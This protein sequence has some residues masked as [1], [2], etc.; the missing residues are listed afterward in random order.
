M[1][2]LITESQFK[3][4]VLENNS[5]QFSE[6]MKIMYSFAKNIVQRVKKKYSLNTKLLLTWGA[7][8]G[9]LVMP[10]DGFIKTG[11][12][13]LDDNQT[14]LILIGCAA[15]MFYDNKKYFERIFEE[16]KNQNLEEPFKQTL[17][18]GLELKKTFVNFISSLRI[19][20]GSVSEI[21]SY[22]FLVPII[23]EIIDFLKTGDF[24]KNLDLVVS[25]IIGSG[26]VLVVAEILRE[27]LRQIKN[28]LTIQ[29]RGN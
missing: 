21:T 15:A 19:S 20:L 7:A 22:G 14:A 17:S 27:L 2:F 12:F 24:E 9:G 13:T 26:L 6:Y 8:L 3:T 23:M 5:E 10:L 16:I 25:R 4:L 28:R 1:D 29:I 11:N 18:K